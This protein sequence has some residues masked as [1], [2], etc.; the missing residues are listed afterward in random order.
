MPSLSQLV[1]CRRE[2]QEIVIGDNIRVIVRRIK[3]GQVRLVVEAPRHVIV[4][5]AEVRS[6]RDC[7]ATHHDP[8]VRPA[9]P[10]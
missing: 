6:R 8:Q 3:R 2:G 1:L 10:A 5:R 9:V 4:D 7:R